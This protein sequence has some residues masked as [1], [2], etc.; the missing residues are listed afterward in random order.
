MAS[1][2]IQFKRRGAFSA[3]TK[4]WD[5]ERC[6]AEILEAEYL[7]AKC[8]TTMF[9]YTVDYLAAKERL[10]ELDAKFLEWLRG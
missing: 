5:R 9:F 1:N 4:G 8:Q 3:I 6:E 2:I 7:A 10:A